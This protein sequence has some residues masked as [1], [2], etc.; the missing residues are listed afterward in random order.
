[1][2]ISNIRTGP[3]DIYKQQADKAERSRK[4][5]GAQEPDRADISSRGREMQH[6]REVL[7]TMPAM[8]PDRVENLKKSIAAG[9]YEPS[10]A[11]IA[12]KMVQ[13]WR[14]DTRR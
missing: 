4:D 6:Y 3:V 11:I 1:M 5:G 9:K 14:L 7:K 13:E 12:E 8:R 2:N 10:P